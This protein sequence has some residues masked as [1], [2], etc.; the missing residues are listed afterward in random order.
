MPEPLCIDCGSCRNG[1]YCNKTDRLVPDYV[2]GGKQY[3]SMLCHDVRS[4]PNL[5][6]SIGK[7]FISR[8]SGILIPFTL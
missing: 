7:W 1:K 8:R 6:G 2:F 4:D 5:C 3:I